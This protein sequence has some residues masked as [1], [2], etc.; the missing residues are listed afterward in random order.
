FKKEKIYSH[1]VKNSKTTRHMAEKNL[2]ALRR[3][4]IFPKNEDK[5]L[6]FL[7]PPEAVSNIQNILSKN[8]FSPND[9][10]LIHPTTRWRFKCWDKFDL[11]LDLL[12]QQKQ[13]IVIVGGCADYEIEMVEKIIGKH[14]KNPS[15]LNL[16]AQ[17]NIDQLAA[18]IKLSKHFYCL[19]S[20][21]FHLANSLNAS[22]TALFGPTCDTTWGSWKNEK[23]KIVKSQISCRPCSLDGCG[24]SKQSE[25]MK[26]INLTDLL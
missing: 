15:V 6:K 7:V 4:G 26:E 20:F 13:K 3:I 2:D 10:V 14:K 16:S 19:D 1:I 17:V 5:Y 9:Y 18:L 25:C 8:D 24:G 21:A 22:V 12:L 11:L 23:A